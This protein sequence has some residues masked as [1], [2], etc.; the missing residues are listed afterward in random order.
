M[1]FTVEDLINILQ[2][3]VKLVPSTARAVIELQYTTEDEEG[4]FRET[5]P[6]T[7]L[8]VGDSNGIKKFIISAF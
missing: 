8:R 5:S 7:S 6:V 4:S 2:A 3:E 1:P